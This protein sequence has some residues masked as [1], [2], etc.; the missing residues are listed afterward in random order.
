MFCR[1]GVVRTAVPDP[2]SCRGYRG[3]AGD[4]L[5]GQGRAALV[6][7]GQGVAEADR[8]SGGDAGRQAQDA[9]LAVFSELI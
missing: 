6:D 1:S 5:D 9:A 8:G 3:G 4:G 7:A 2:T